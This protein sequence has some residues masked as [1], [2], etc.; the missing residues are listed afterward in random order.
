[1]YNQG[2]KDIINV[3]ISTVVI[4]QMSERNKDKPEMTWQVMDILK[5]TFPDEKFDVVIDKSTID[6]IL[7]GDYS[8][9]NTAIML[10]EV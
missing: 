7:C 6:A 1:M 3:D 10:H 4:E 2:Y 9:Y 8:F 5:M